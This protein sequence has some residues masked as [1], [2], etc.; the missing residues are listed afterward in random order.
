MKALFIPVLVA[1]SLALSG[2]VI[3]IDDDHD[4]MSFSS[5]S[6]WEKQERKN[7]DSIAKFELGINQEQVLNTLGS[8]DFNE[9][10]SVNGENVQVLYY[11]TQRVREDGLTTKDECTPL[12]FVN[13]SLVGWGDA[14]VTRH[15]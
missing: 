8:A 10:V 4:G 14:A 9:L 13:N 12:V 11:R 15:L 7:R 6:G 3:S 1:S 2:C 5:Q